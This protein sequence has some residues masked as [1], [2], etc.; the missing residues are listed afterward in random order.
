[1]WAARWSWQR[2]WDANGGNLDP[3]SGVMP[4]E[5]AHP[6]GPVVSALAIGGGV[7][8]ACC[9]GGLPDIELVGVVLGELGVRHH[10]GHAERLE[11]GEQLLSGPPFLVGLQQL[12]RAS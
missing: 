10:V 7:C 2:I 3:L 6:P 5:D 9:F 12:P 11:G 4:E 8:P 1:M